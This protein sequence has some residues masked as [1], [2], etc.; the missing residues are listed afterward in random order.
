MP[1]KL[2][3]MDGAL[4]LRAAIHS[5]V[6]ERE[7]IL[8]EDAVTVLV[9]LDVGRP[10]FVQILVV[11]IFCSLPLRELARESRQAAACLRTAASSAGLHG[12]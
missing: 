5:S 8:A 1:S 6:L 9:Q 4:G 7:G 3:R 12:Q 2:N 10:L 11:E